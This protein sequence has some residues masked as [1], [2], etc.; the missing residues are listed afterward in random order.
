MGVNRQ[1][2]LL[3]DNWD[4]V[5]VVEYPHLASNQS[6]RMSRFCKEGEG[7]ASSKIAHL[8]GIPSR[9][10][11]SPEILFSLKECLELSNLIRAMETAVKLNFKVNLV[12]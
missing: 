5:V 9:K 7:S 6:M 10:P 3:K 12:P 11:F 1:L 8:K 4:L 2:L